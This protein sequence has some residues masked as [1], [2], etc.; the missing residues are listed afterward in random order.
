MKGESAQEGKITFIPVGYVL[1]EL[2]RRFRAG[3]F[4][5]F[6]KVDDLYR[7]DVHMNNVGKYVV[8]LTILAALMDYDVRQFGRVPKSYTKSTAN[9]VKIDLNMADYLQE[10]VWSVV[11][12]KPL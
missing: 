1:S 12:S 8:G 4:P 3:E 6:N 9:F 10:I 7:D 5:G 2:D 11:N